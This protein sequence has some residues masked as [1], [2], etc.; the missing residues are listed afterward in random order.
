M[1]NLF[2]RKRRVGK[3][4]KCFDFKEANKNKQFTWK[5]TLITESEFKERWPGAY[6]TLKYYEGR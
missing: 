4:P 1:V 5:S 6:E 2:D 3:T